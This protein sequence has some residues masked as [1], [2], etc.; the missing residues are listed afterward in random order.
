MN[1]TT[2]TSA[3]LANNDSVWVIMTNNATCP[4]QAKDTSAH[5]K[6]TVNAKPVPVITASGPTSFCPGSNVILTASGGTSYVWSNAKTTAKDTVTASATY[7]VTATNAAGCTATAASVITVYSPAVVV[8][9][10]SP[11]CLTNTINL[12]A[13]PSGGTTYTY[14]WSGPAS[15]SSTVMNPSRASAVRA[16]TGI[17]SVT[18]TDNHGCTST[19]TTDIVVNSDPPNSSFTICNGSAFNATPSGFSSLITYSWSAPSISPAGSITGAS[20]QTNASIPGQT[21]TNTTSSQATATYTITP[22]SSCTGAS[23]IV[24]VTVNG[25]I[26]IPS[27]TTPA[28][29][30]SGGLDTITG[31]GSTGASSYSFW[32]AATGGSAVTTSTTPPGTVSGNSLITPTTLAGGTYTYY[33]EG[34]NGSCASTSRQAVTITINTTPSLPSG[35]LVFAS[36]AC[37]LASVSLSGASSS[38]YWET[39]STGTNTSLPSTS[40]YTITSTGG[41]FVRAYTG[42]CWSVGADST[43]TVTVDAGGSLILPSSSA[44]GTTESCGDTSGWTYYAPSSNLNNWMFAINKNGN[45]FTANVDITIDP[46]G[47]EVTADNTQFLATI[48]MGRYWNVTV[49]SGSINGSTNPVSVRFFYDPA[50]TSAMRTESDYYNTLWHGSSLPY[51]WFKT[52]T[53]IT[54][55]PANNGYSNIPNKLNPG[56]FSVQYGTLG[57]LSYVEYDGL[58]GFSGGTGLITVMGNT[59]LPVQLISLT[60]TPIDNSY[61]KLNWATASESNNSGFDIERSVNGIDFEKVGFVQ[62]HGTTSSQNDY[63]YPDQSADPNITYYYRLRQIDIDG[64]YTFSKIVSALLIGHHGFIMDNLKP[65]PASSL[66]TVNTVA[67]EAQDATVSLVDM[68]GRVLIEQSWQ[69][70]PGLNG[71]Q[72]DVSKLAPGTY[73]VSVSG[74]SYHFS[75]TLVIAR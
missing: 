45:N 25:T 41:V 22:S 8:T 66:V 67:T 37:N 17:Y 38:Y 1:T 13:T 26:G 69:M 52:T 30:C 9:S 24:T 56:T 7:T 53:G 16:D 72:L 60:A 54:Y 62:G 71:T 34:D 51:E 20:A 33:V 35:P 23:Y 65:N 57:G 59:S 32:T 61:V 50:D 15:F 31:T 27:S 47:Y 68:L 5:I 46:A 4:T 73:T 6:M 19:G 21:L 74:G 14:S 2:Y 29:I 55:D 49:T 70:G 48:T 64:K 18:V 63:Q 42:L 40:P 10:N 3:T 44:L 39:S 28:A 43:G 36:P 75:K 12:L 11:V 58:Q